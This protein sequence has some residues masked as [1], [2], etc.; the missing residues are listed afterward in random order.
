MS[1]R[2]RKAFQGIQRNKSMEKAW[3]IGEKEVIGTGTEQGEAS[4][5]GCL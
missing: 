1:K 5:Q 4:L 3:H 2:K